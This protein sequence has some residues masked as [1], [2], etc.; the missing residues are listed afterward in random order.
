M[1]DYA[2]EYLRTLARIDQGCN[3]NVAAC[4]CDDCA[5]ERNPD[6]VPS[7]RLGPSITAYV[8]EVPLEDGTVGIGPSGRSIV[9]ILVMLREMVPMPAC[10]E[11]IAGYDGWTYVYQDGTGM[12]YARFRASV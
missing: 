6:F 12:S 5:L 4:C 8:S 1:L 10:I 11:L 7:V 9:E 2:A 3:G